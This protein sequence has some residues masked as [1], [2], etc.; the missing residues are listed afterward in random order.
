MPCATRDYLAR[1]I[2]RQQM[3]P[4]VSLELELLCIHAKVSFIGSTEILSYSC[5]GN[6]VAGA[7]PSFA[8]A[9]DMPRIEKK[10][11]CFAM[12]VDGKPFLLL[13]A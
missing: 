6:R 8:T 3:Q 5:D 1:F 12:M 4:G 10:D 9:D 13:G 11:G 2:P 7:L